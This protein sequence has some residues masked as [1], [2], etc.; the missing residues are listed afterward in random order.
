MDW[1]IFGQLTRNC[2]K[3][4]TLLIFRPRPNFTTCQNPVIDAK[5][6]PQLQS[7]PDTNTNFLPLWTHLH[8]KNKRRMLNFSDGFL[9]INHWWPHWYRRINERYFSSRLTEN[10]IANTAN[11]FKWGSTPF[12]QI[13]VANG[14][15]ETP[16]ATAEFQFQVADIF[17]KE[18]F[19]VMTN[20]TSAIF[21]LLFV[22]WK[23]T[24]LYMR[25]GVLSFPF[26]SMQLKHADN[27]YWNI[28]EPSLNS[29][30]ILIQPG[31]TKCDLH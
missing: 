13:M 1:S 27:T 31:N 4:S 17:F 9:R 19:I 14:H 16:N 3:S 28:N 6:I 20:L 10:W 23:S 11:N 25:Q 29:T 8:F 21:G 12:Y 18:R 22:Q 24:I 2:P 15:L 30:E 5:I 26:F 7:T